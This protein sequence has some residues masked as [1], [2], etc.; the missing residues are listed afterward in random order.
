MRAARKARRE[1]KNCVPVILPA[2]KMLNGSTGT[3]NGILSNYGKNTGY[4]RVSIL[5]ST[6]RQ[7]RNITMRT[8]KSDGKSIANGRLQIRKGFVKKAGG[9]VKSIVKS[10]R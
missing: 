9:T 5:K 4:I 8:G 10:W 7:R 3:E 6:G 2:E 1:E